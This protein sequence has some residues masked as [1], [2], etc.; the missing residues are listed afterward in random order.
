[1][2][3]FWFITILMAGGV[4]AW[5]AAYWSVTACR[6]ISLIA[7]ILNLA[8]ATVLWLDTPAELT[9]G[10]TWIVS[11]EAEWIPTFGIGFDLALD[12]LSLLML[13]LTFLLGAIAVITSWREVQYRAGFFHFNLLFR[14]LIVLGQHQHLRSLRME[15]V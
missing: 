7:M 12:G 6:W 11:L 8:L 3:L 2:I 9:P 14:L 10:Q 4:L 5:I 13:L 1:M 15:L